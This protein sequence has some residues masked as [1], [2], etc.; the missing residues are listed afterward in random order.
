MRTLSS[1][2][3]TVL[4][5]FA[6]SLAA[7]NPSL[8]QTMSLPPGV[9]AR[10]TAVSPTG[11]LVAAAC[12]DAKIRVWDVAS[13]ALR[14]TLD[15]D[16]GRLNVLQFSP[17]G[18]LLTGGTWSGM[19]RV[20]DSS[21][22]LQ[23]EFKEAA[24]INAIA[25]T[26][27]RTVIA[28]SVAEQPIEIRNLGTGK[29][30]ASLPATFSDSSALAF[31]RDGQWL[32]SADADTEIR[33]FDARRL[34]LHARVTDLLLEPMA[35]KFSADGRQ[36]FAGG[37]DGV[38]TL[39]DSSTGKITKAFPKQPD[40]LSAICVSADGRSIATAYFNANDPSKPTPV[41]LWDRSTSWLRSTIPTP[42]SGFTGGDFVSDGTLLLTSSSDKQLQVWATR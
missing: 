33:I 22:A 19:L 29:L 28:I 17:D 4:L 41:Q 35:V 9:T 38:L 24:R 30:L 20:W 13:G 12:S 3:A 2:L 1:L 36:L 10:F 23:R 8:R 42:A 15:L 32:A 14:N 31:S 21:G 39:I 6:S 27:D 25:V 11:K 34:Q 26:T 37:A 16:D 40:V 5:L 18:E 7:D